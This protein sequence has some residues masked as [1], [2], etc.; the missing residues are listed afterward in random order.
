MVDSAGVKIHYVTAGKADGPL[1]VMVHGYPDCW[2]T[3]RHLITELAPDYHCVAMDQRGYN[4]SDKP[5]GVANYDRKLLIDDIEAVIHAEGRKS[6]ILIGHDWG[7]STS[8][9]V[10]LQR[11]QL[12]DRLVCMSVPHPANMARE[13]RD[14][15]AQQAGSQYA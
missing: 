8:W 3:W 15:P 2:Y 6:C 4:L 12:V 5:E 14:N 11:P 7:S 1:V 10:A 9:A 13:L